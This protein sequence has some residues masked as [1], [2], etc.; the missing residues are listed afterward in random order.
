[1]TNN[2]R[3]FVASEKVEILPWGFLP[4][5]DEFQTLVVLVVSKPSTRF[6]FSFW[7]CWVV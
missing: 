7:K 5:L 2:R 3:Q 6:V 1:M 4:I